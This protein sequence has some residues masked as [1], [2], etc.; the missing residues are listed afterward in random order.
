MQNIRFNF[1][2][3]ESSRVP[4]PCFVRDHTTWMTASI[5]AQMTVSHSITE[6]FYRF[7]SSSKCPTPAKP[8]GLS[9]FNYIRLFAMN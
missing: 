7:N 1:A 5:S 8:K 2:T 6:E 4:D 9:E 3:Y